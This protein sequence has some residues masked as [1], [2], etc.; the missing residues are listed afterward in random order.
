MS[1]SVAVVLCLVAVILGGVA[2]PARAQPRD[3]RIPL[4]PVDQTESTNYYKAIEDAKKA[5]SAEYSE[6]RQRF[7]LVFQLG[8]AKLGY[9]PGP[10]DGNLTARTVAAIRTYEQNR[11][12]TP[13]GDPLTFATLQ[14]IGKDVDAVDKE[15]AWLP[16][17]IFMDGFWD[18]GWVYATGTWDLLNDT[19][20]V[21]EQTSHIECERQTMKCTDTVATLSRIKGSAPILSLDVR[22]YDIERWDAHE[23]VT[24]FSEWGF[25][26]TRDVVRLNR[27][28]KS[29]TA[30]RSTISTTGACKGVAPQDFNRSLVDGQTIWNEQWSEWRKALDGLMLISPEVRKLVSQ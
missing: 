14:Q 4:L 10:F 19:V 2:P 13:T 11:G 28:Q 25:G 9:E 26:C 5:G 17:Y 29:V 22:R 16:G 30:V 7:T 8:L 18:R 27:L 6:L 15:P 12:L 21:P 1:K 3:V 24:K 20:A 23:I